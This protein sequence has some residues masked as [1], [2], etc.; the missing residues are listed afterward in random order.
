[1]IHEVISKWHL[2]MA[3]KL[4]GGLD[5][6]LDDDV[7][8]LSPIVFTPQE[9]KAITKLYL[10]AAGQTLPGEK[11]ISDSANETDK[12][13]R[14]IKEVLNGN[15]A[16]LEFETYVEGKYVNGIDMI[17]CND[18]GKITEFK[19]MI[20]PLQAINLVHKQMGEMLERMKP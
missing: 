12:S 16:V 14:Y 18:A 11:K 20:R 9:G 8:F 13:F 6:L 4:P 7:V 5:E 17:T 1:M 3:G 2:H 15:T 19:V 10:Q